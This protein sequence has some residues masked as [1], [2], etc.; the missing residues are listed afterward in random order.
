[1]VVVS[2]LNKNI[3]ESTDLAKKGTDRRICIPLLYV[4]P[5]R[6]LAGCSTLQCCHATP[7]WRDPTR[8]K[9]LSGCN[10]W[11]LDWTQSSRC[12]PQLCFIVTFYGHLHSS[13]QYPAKSPAVDLLILSTLRSTKSGFLTP[14]SNNEAIRP[15]S[16]GVPPPLLL[17]HSFTRDRRK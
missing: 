7:Y 4:H 16:I 13:A 12:N 1:M 8:S 11:L 17:L 6:P 14:K 10:S 15:F 5:P 2:D 9:Q 3:G